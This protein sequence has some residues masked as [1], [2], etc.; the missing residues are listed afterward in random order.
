MGWEDAQ[1]VGSWEDAPLAEEESG[2]AKRRSEKYNPDTGKGEYIW[3][4]AKSGAIGGTAGIGGLIADAYT[5]PYKYLYNKFADKDVPYLG[6]TAQ[7]IELGDDLIGVDRDMLPPDVATRYMGSIAE[8]AGGSIIPG[9]FIIKKAAHPLLATAAEGA[10]ITTG[11]LGAEFGGDIAEE[12]G[13]NRA[14]GEIPGGLITGTMGYSVPT[15]ASKVIGAGKYAD[16][17]MSSTAGKEIGGIVKAEGTDGDITKSF[18]TANTIESETGQAF[19]PTL[20]GRTKST[21][22]NDLEQEVLG[23]DIQSAER[24][25]K[26]QESNVLNLQTYKDKKFPSGG[27]IDRAAKEKIILATKNI[28][29]EERLLAAEMESV[30]QKVVGRPQQ[31]SGEKLYDLMMLKRQS[32]KDA[33]SKEI[34]RIYRMADKAGINESMDDVV[35]VVKAIAGDDANAFQK[36]PPVFSEIKSR[37]IKPDVVSEGSMIVDKTGKSITP[38]TTTKADVTASFEE[39]HSLYKEVNRQLNAAKGIKDGTSHF[40]LSKLKDSLQSKLKKFEGGGYGAVAKDFKQWNKDYSN[41]AQTYKEGVAGRMSATGRY[42][43]LLVK[44]NIFKKFFTPSG[45]DDFNRIYANDATA[46]RLLNDAILDEYAR[47]VGVF[48]DGKINPKSAVTFIKRN[49]EALAKMPELRGVLLDTTKATEALLAKNARLTD[50]RKLLDRNILSRIA[51][52]DNPMPTIEK[53]L[54]N[55]K[56]LNQ[57]LSLPGKARGSA[58]NL[59]AQAI[60][61]AAA[62]QRMTVSE[63]LDLN[64][65]VIRPALNKYGSDHYKNVKTIADA[66]DMLSFSKPPQHPSLT[67]FST[68]PIQQWTGT[69]GPSLISQYRATTITRQSSPVHMVSSMGTRF[70]MKLKGDDAKRMQEYILTHPTAAKDFAKAIKVNDSKFVANRLRYHALAAGIR[71][72]AVATEDMSE[73]RKIVGAD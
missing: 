2:L 40:F 15:A 19:N 65:S 36:L 7:A 33:S 24:A 47:T 37:Y 3:N 59:V 6:I 55:R 25:I 26:T 31:E 22:L 72:F 52:V 12:S 49:N 48:T 64:E 14:W 35:D 53:A 4:S 1:V 29:K 11:G 30:G 71:S 46:T 62:K 56:E 68:D 61:S 32:A 57:L 8:F 34:E 9:S 69:T 39:I 60:P 17:A 27:D 66:M 13:V 50:A 58:L 38:P 51:N 20:S 10:A 16:E 54:T 73:Q 63:F 23:R 44:E 18:N 28:D 41:Y 67:Q 70:W 42:G 5:F 45:V 43:D 21:I